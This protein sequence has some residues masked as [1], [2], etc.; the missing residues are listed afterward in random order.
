MDGL[1][2]SSL[3]FKNTIQY[4]IM[5]ICWILITILIF[6]SLIFVIL[7]T[8]EYATNGNYFSYDLLENKELNPMLDIAQYEDQFTDLSK[9]DYTVNQEGNLIT[10]S[11]DI[12]QGAQRG[13]LLMGGR[14]IDFSL[15]QEGQKAECTIDFRYF[16]EDSAQVFFQ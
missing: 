16:R 15:E 2:I 4:I 3:Y 10:L 7:E 12:P 8:A 14:Q 13:Y 11:V 1:S 6:F 9:M 5:R